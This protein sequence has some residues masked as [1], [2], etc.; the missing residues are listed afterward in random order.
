MRLI[1]P[2][3]DQSHSDAWLGTDYIQSKMGIGVIV[4]PNYKHRQSAHPT[5]LDDEESPGLF[6][7]PPFW[8]LKFAKIETIFK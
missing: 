5:R 6:C 4:W 2:I 1:F 8:L 7:K 3:C